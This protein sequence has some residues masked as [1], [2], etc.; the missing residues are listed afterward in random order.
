MIIFLTK[1]LENREE[2]RLKIK[3]LFQ[4]FTGILGDPKKLDSNCS[5]DLTDKTIQKLTNHHKVKQAFNNW[6]INLAKVGF[7]LTEDKK[8]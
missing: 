7:R 1:L 3:F 2:G 8:S 6:V 4:T 5:N